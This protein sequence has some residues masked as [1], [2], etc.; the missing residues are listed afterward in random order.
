[1]VSYS[2][3]LPVRGSNI[4]SEFSCSFKKM[5]INILENNDLIHPNSTISTRNSDRALSCTNFY[6]SVLDWI[7]KKEV[8]G[9]CNFSSAYGS[10]QWK[11]ITERI[12]F[13]LPEIFE[14]YCT[15]NK[16]PLHWYG[17][18]NYIFNSEL[19]K[20]H[21]NIIYMITVVVSTVCRLDW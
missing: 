16:M 21:L 9:L 20:K 18:W 2:A 4:K 6:F 7:M 3:I 15:K 8:R 5:L 10:A 17:T 11:Y 14:T 1:M 12:F 13:I 19:K